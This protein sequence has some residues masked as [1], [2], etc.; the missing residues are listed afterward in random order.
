VLGLIGLI[1]AWRGRSAGIG[2]FTMLLVVYPLVYYIGNP[3]QRYRHP[4]DPELVVLAAWAITGW[5]SGHFFSPG[6]K[7][8]KF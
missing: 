8:K 7:P 2:L 5:R 4:I 3:E 6:L 1:Q